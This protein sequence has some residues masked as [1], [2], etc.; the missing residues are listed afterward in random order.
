M[1]NETGYPGEHV[2]WPGF[3]I[4]GDSQTDKKIDKQTDQC[5]HVSEDWD[6]QSFWTLFII[7]P[8]HGIFY[9]VSDIVTMMYLLSPNRNSYMTVNQKSGNRQY[10]VLQSDNC[11]PHFRTNLSRCQ[12]NRLRWMTVRQFFA[13]RFYQIPNQIP[14]CGAGFCA[15]S[16]EKLKVNKR[17][18]HLSFTL[19]KV[20]ISGPIHGTRGETVSHCRFT[21]CPVKFL[22]SIGVYCNQ[23]RYL[24]RDRNRSHIHILMNRWNS[25]RQLFGSRF[26]QFL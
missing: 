8:S 1:F 4:D 9:A 23:T 6:L 26:E 21:R 2:C 14:K 13:R 7:L 17:Y 12:Q 16:E 15:Y 19:C 3:S 11:Q 24:V 10:S 5:K 25:S 20:E 22:I 18:I